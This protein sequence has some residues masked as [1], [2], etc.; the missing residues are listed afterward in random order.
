MLSVFSP[1]SLFHNLI[2][3]K[4]EVDV[5]KIMHVIEM[6]IAMQNAND[7]S[8]GFNHSEK[9]VWVQGRKLSREHHCT[10]KIYLG[11]QHN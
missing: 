11:A 8:N 10:L 1:Y 5:K 3:G 9:N 4:R 7:A 2:L 6:E